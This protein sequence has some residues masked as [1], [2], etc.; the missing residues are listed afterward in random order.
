MDKLKRLGVRGI[1]LTYARE[2][3]FDHKTNKAQP[4]GHI[5]NEQSVAADYCPNIEAWRKGTH[6]T[7]DLISE[8]DYLALKYGSSVLL[9]LNT[10]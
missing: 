5:L 2:T 8:G 3:V 6:E 4:Q 10:D 1:I 7:I 9:H